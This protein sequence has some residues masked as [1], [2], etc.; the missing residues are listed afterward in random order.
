MGR[1]LIAP[2]APFISGL[3]FSRSLLS[4]FFQI[5]Q[6]VIIAQ[7]GRAHSRRHR[8][9]GEGT[10]RNTTN[11]SAD[12]KLRRRGR[13]RTLTRV[14]EG[15]YRGSLERRNSKE[16]FGR[17][18]RQQHRRGRE[19]NKNRTC[20][21][22]LLSL[23]VHVT[24]T[25]AWR[26][27]PGP[28]RPRGIIR[29]AEILLRYPPPMHDAAPRSPAKPRPEAIPRFRSADDAHVLQWRVNYPG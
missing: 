26:C 19:E 20:A 25:R 4:Y 27:R 3:L 21:A 29:I 23:A 2:P 13:G 7:S 16:W 12:R 1:P 9:S 5:N 15:E 17:G 22:Y 10:K 24:L 11:S 8:R 14:E 18:R 28:S 6:P